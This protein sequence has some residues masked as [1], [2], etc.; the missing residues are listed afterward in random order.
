MSSPVNKKR[1]SEDP[2]SPLRTKRLDGK[3]TPSSG[4]LCD[5]DESSDGDEKLTLN[6]L[7]NSDAYHAFHRWKPPGDGTIELCCV[8]EW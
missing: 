6:Q 5:D 2:L 1:A 4:T 7:K 3:E 8:D